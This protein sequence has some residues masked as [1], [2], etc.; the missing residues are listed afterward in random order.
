MLEQPQQRPMF[1]I[2]RQTQLFQYKIQQ[3]ILMKDEEI[4][5][6]EATLRSLKR[7]IADAH[8]TLDELDHEIS[9]QVTSK[10]STQHASKVNSKIE[11]AKKNQLHQQKLAD[12]QEQFDMERDEIN[13]QFE[14][15]LSNCRNGPLK[16]QL[17][18]V[19]NEIDETRNAIE[20]YHQKLQQQVKVTKDFEEGESKEYEDQV[21]MISQLQ[22]VVE[23]KNQERV[24]NLLRSKQRLSDCIGL[25]ERMQ[26]QHIQD[27]AERNRQIEVIDSN[28]Q[29][30][31]RQLS[32]EHLRTMS[33][34]KSRKQDCIKK[35]SMLKRA[36]KKLQDGNRAQIKQ[37]KS[38]F[39][40]IHHKFAASAPVTCTGPLQTEVEE[41]H[42]KKMAAVQ[43]AQAVLASKEEKLT[44]V[45]KANAALQSQLGRA[46]HTFQYGTRVY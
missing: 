5:R 4:D 23:L 42:R 21:N 45:R 37:T 9:V 2:D 27:V 35:L 28:Y 43:Q 20:S 15:R 3:A 26:Q 7:Q 32:M 29:R 18:D 34:L 24:D 33:G 14:H 31:V 44:E 16:Q 41:K 38:E 13:A 10:R 39:A 6:L 8:G 1:W 25:I 40:Q 36:H 17:D 19:Q 22:K 12:L 30:S 11:L 46:R